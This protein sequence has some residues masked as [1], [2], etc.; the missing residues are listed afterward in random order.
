MHFL[1]RLNKSLFPFKDKLIIQKRAG[2]YPAN[3]FVNKKIRGN[4]KGLDISSPY[5]RNK[6]IPYRE[7]MT[8]RNKKGVDYIQP[9][10][11]LQEDSSDERMTGGEIKRGWI[12]PA[13]LHYTFIEKQELLA[14]DFHIF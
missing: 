12:S 14:A 10:H 3:T 1:N 13:P 11:S 4:K 8:G 9:L 2:L 7:E 6:K 5:I